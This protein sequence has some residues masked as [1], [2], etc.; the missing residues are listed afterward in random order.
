MTATEVSELIALLVA[1]YPQPHWPP[2]TQRLYALLLEDLD[3]GAAR[4][5]VRAW[6][7]SR[8]E[9]PTVADV[10]DAVRRILEAA[11]ALPAAPEPEAAWALVRRGFSTVGRYRPFPRT[12]A[13]VAEVVDALGWQALCD[14]ANEDVIR[15]QF[16]RLYREALE[17]ARRD[18]C[19][20][21]RLALPGQPAPVLPAPAN[22][23]E[24]AV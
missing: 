11:G 9:R 22:A 13:L 5:A 12:P 3:A 23:A 1:A 18:T 20:R 7:D 2:E 14:S 19:A 10:R 16:L 21:T 17:R 24:A 6:I 4:L 15:G 8:A